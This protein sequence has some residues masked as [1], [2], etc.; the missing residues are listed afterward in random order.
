MEA[1]ASYVAL[2]DSMSIDRYPGPGLGAASLL[3]RNDDERFPEF[4]GR[5]LC[6]AHTEL[7][8]TCLAFDGATTRDVLDLLR[9]RAPRPTPQPTLVTLTAGGNDL[10]ASRFRPGSDTPESIAERID[11]CL[12]AIR[13]VFAPRRIVLATIYDP[14]DGVGDL[15]AQWKTPGPT[16]AALEQLNAQ[17]RA[18]AAR[19]SDVALAEVYEP[20]LGH[21]AHHAEADHP[22]HCPD[23]PSCWIKLRIEPNARGGSEVRRAFWSA[24]EG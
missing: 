2:G 15:W 10:L 23:D 13:A 6:S 22:R 17:I 3:A 4:A 18:L 9:Q 12:N 20:F 8:F 14:T 5:D 19:D 16:L 24:L 11:Q 7:A 21:G 1:F